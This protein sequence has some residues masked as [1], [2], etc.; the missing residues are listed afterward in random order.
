MTAQDRR[1]LLILGLGNVLCSDDGLGVAAIELLR[2][3]YLIPER[4]RVLDGGTLGLSLLSHI[5]A[6]DDLVLADAI[7]GGGPPG[8][9]V[10][11]EGED[12]GPAVRTRLTPHQIGVADLLDTLHLLGASPRHLV[13]LGLVPETLRLGLGLSRAVAAQLITLVDSIVEE[14]CR[15]GYELLPSPG[16][17]LPL[18]RDRTVRALGIFNS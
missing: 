9:M 2:R 14:A 5:Q 18:S 10:R 15:L 16:D 8:T 4:V 3:R 6:S 11:L 1:T 17:E 7:S 13:L 12:V